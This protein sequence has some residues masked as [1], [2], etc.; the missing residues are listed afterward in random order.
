MSAQSGLVQSAQS[1]L[2]QKVA[3][4]WIVVAGVAY[5]YDM[6]RSTGNSLTDASGRP[7]GDDFVN[8]WAGAFL[9]WH[10]RVA[11]VFDWPA[12]HAFQQ[13]IVGDLNPYLYGYSPILLVLTAPLAVLPYLPGLWVWLVSGWF[14]FY[15]IGRAHV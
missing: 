12:Y 10:G 14:C 13:S 6:L 2:V 1:D 8:Y 9:A 5:A 11:E 4:T 7:L 3:R 15:Q